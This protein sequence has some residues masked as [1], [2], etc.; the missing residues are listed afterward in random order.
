MAKPRSLELPVATADE[1]A[2][3]AAR[4]EL[5][6]A[7]LV[8]GALKS[9]PALVGEPGG[10]RKALPLTTDDDD[11]RDLHK[12]LDKLADDKARGKSLDD[13][14]ALAWTARR[15]QILAWVERIAH[16]DEGQ[17]ADDLDSGLRD[18]ATATTAGPRLLEL[19]RSPY[20]RVRALVAAHKAAP[21][22]ALKL[23]ASDKERIV[24]EA[25]EQ[26]A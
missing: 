22:E 9:A 23:L 6:I 4:S 11:P 26:R 25:L 13:A 16:V 2:A 19:A 21:P 3:A 5:S 1:I 12:R 10:A 17:K 7:F 18:A 24:M 15:A 8:L 20:P 14:V